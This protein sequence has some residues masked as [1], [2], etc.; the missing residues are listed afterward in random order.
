MCMHTLWSQV[1]KPS[2]FVLT[3]RGKGQITNT[4]GLQGH[5]EVASRLRDVVETKKLKTLWAWYPPL[6]PLSPLSSPLPPPRLLIMHHLVL[7]QLWGAP[8]FTGRRRGWECLSCWWGQEA[9][10]FSHPSPYSLS[11]SLCLLL[12]V[13]SS[14]VAGSEKRSLSSYQHLPLS[15]RHVMIISSSLTLYCGNKEIVF[16]QSLFCLWA[17]V[18]AQYTA[19]LKLFN[20]HNAKTSLTNFRIQKIVQL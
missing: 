18:L 11:L 5:S 9:V 19:V 15:R 20:L 6:Q 16:I 3:F 2:S 13:I 17:F 4:L 10:F 14:Q 1:E 8:K 7:T 12:V